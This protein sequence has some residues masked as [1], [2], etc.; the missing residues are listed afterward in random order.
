MSLNL[1]QFVTVPRQNFRIAIDKPGLNCLDLYRAHTDS[2]NQITR[3]KV[4]FVSL[5][6]QHLLHRV[7]LTACDLGANTARALNVNKHGGSIRSLNCFLKRYVKNS[8]T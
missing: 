2:T 3:H 4:L 8:L 6:F 1:D 5:I 7:F